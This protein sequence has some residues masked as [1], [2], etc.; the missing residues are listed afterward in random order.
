MTD[1]H[2]LLYLAVCSKTASLSDFSMGTLTFYSFND[3][4]AHGIL[5]A[6]YSL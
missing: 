5:H 3:A 4:V 1:H 6:T 2:N